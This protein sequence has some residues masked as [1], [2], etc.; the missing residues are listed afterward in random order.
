MAIFDFKIQKYKVR[1]GNNLTDEYGYISVVMRGMIDCLGFDED[2]ITLY[3]L[4]N[5]ILP[6]QAY[7][8]DKKH[9]IMFLP[10][11]DITLYIDILRNEK[12]VYAHCDSESPDR[13]EIITGYEKVGE[14][15]GRGTA[16]PDELPPH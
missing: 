15:E 7:F 13:I 3:F 12:P 14:E 16:A 8:P 1:I 10:F 2:R 5:K 4:D 11:S 6:K 9:A